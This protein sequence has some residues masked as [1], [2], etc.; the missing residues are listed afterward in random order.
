[1]LSL[2]LS[3]NRSPSPTINTHRQGRL[4][5][6]SGRFGEPS[7]PACDAGYSLLFLC[8]RRLARLIHHKSFYPGEFLLEAGH[9]VA[10]S[11]LKKHDEA[12]REKQEQSDPEK[13]AKQRHGRDVNLLGL[14]GQR[15]R[16][17]S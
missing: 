6:A 2:N 8:R 7:L 15:R 14:C 5:E 12:E 13:G 17:Q 16:R 1:M 3:N 4:S 10:R 11:I 9:E